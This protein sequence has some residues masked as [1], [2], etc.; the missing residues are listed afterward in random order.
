[1]NSKYRTAV[2][3]P[4][5]SGADIVLCR[6]LNRQRRRRRFF[7]RRGQETASD[8]AVDI[9]QDCEIAQIRLG[10]RTDGMFVDEDT[11]A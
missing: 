10:K 6:F 4:T 3:L 11:Q 9:H 5:V 2:F 1:M 8:V 7:F